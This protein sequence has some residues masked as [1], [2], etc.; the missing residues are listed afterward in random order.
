MWDKLIA[1]YETI[2]FTNYMLNLTT[3]PDLKAVIIIGQDTIKK[4]ILKLEKMMQKFAVPLPGK[5]PETENTAYSLDAISDKYIFRQIY[6]GIQSFLPLHMVAFEE[7]N[8]P[9]VRKNFKFLLT[10]EINIYESF[11]SY[12]LL[13]GWVYKPP[14]FKR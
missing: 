4:Q 9:T 5:P 6:K 12:G 8:T 13:K 10:E 11:I 2:E 14:S 1:R 3:D 7:S